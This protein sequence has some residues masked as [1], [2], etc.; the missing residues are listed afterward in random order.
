MP[1]NSG[2]SGAYDFVADRRPVA[3]LFRRFVVGARENTLVMCHPG[4]S[5]ETLRQ[6]DVMTSARDAELRYLSS[7]EW[8]ALLRARALDLGPYRRL[9]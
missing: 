4:Y 3:D 5:D 8:E 2:F 9:G 1:V 6:L 7:P